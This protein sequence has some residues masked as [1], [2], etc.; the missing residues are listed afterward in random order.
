LPP[1]QLIQVGDAYFVRDGHHRISVAH[2]LGQASIDAEVLIWGRSGPTPR[3]SPAKP[4]PGSVSPA[5][6][7]ARRGSNA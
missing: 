5:H 7:L 2:H 1:V 3:N 6:G 4:F